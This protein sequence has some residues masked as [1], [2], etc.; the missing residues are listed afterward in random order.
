MK[1]HGGEHAVLMGAGPEA[2]LAPGPSHL[3]PPEVYEEMRED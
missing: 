2:E 3:G 1:H